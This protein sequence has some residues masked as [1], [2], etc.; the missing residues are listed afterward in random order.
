M[1]RLRQQGPGPA[2]ALVG[3]P[4]HPPRLARRALPPHTAA[5]AAPPRPA[6]GLQEWVE[7]QREKA[8]LV[9]PGLPVYDSMLDNYEKVGVK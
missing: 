8:A 6:T 9:D 2:S 4:T 5:L 1:L 3:A 7:L